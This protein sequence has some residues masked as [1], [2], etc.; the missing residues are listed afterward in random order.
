MSSRARPTLTLLSRLT[1]GG[2]LG[3]VL[4]LVMLLGGGKLGS[5]GG[6][7]GGSGGGCGGRL[8]EGGCGGEGGGEASRNAAWTSCDASRLACVR[9][10]LITA[11]R[12]V[13]SKSLA[14]GAA[15]VWTSVT[16]YSPCV[17]PGGRRG[18]GEGRGEGGGGRGGGS[19]GGRGGGGD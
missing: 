5:D 12:A 4:G 13:V 16:Q 18:G 14:V 2:L 17:A 8:G 9:R 11:V 7:Y 19:G 15:K 6:P 3:G 10:L 1:P